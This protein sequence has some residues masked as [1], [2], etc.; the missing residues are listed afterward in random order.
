VNNLISRT[1]QR[2]KAALNCEEVWSIGTE[3]VVG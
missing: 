3:S 1:V 2:I